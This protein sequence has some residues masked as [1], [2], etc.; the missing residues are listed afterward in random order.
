MKPIF[1]LFAAMLVLCGCSTAQTLYRPDSLWDPRGGYKD[2]KLAD[3]RYKVTYAAN[4]LVTKQQAEDL[5]TMRGA[6]LCQLAGYSYFRMVAGTTTITRIMPY[7][8]LQPTAE[9]EFQCSF[10]AG[11]GLRRTDDVIASTR[12]AY[13]KV[14]PKDKDS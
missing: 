14:M 4:G 1:L 3:D 2:A 12:A 11:P 5:A 10:A 7:G 6:E 9:G 13:P 8:I